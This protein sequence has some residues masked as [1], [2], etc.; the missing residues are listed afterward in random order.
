MDLPS[1]FLRIENPYTP[2]IRIANPNEREVIARAMI[3]LNCF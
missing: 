2:H 1:D 3:V